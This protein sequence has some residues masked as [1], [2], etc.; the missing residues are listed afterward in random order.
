LGPIGIVVG[1]LVV[2]LLQTT[3]GIIRHELSEMKDEDILPDRQKKSSLSM[4][5]LSELIRKVRNPD[6]QST[7]GTTAESQDQNQVIPKTPVSSSGPGDPLSTA[8]EGPAPTT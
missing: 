6:K 7:P 8:N 5:P 4:K 2:T 1:P 3:L